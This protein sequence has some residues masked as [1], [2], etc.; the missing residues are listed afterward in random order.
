MLP[1]ISFRSLL[2]DHPPLEPLYLDKPQEDIDEK[3]PY[4]ITDLYCQDLWCDC[5]KVHLVIQNN[6]GAIMATISYGWKSK[7]YYYK[8]GLDEYV[9][10]SITTG[11]LDPWSEQSIHGPLFLKIVQVKLKRERQFLS[12]IKKR[13]RLFKKVVNSIFYVPI[14]SPDPTLPENVVS[15]QTYRR[16]KP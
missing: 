2:P 11:F 14:A 6:Q 3:G 1:Q 8:W 4:F 9:A 16:R 7:L 5:H 15:I 13:Y 12:T 10:D